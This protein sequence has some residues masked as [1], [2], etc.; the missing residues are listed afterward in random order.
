MSVHIITANS[1]E[2]QARC[3]VGRQGSPLSVSAI[4]SDRR[5]RY[6]QVRISG[7]KLLVFWVIHVTIFTIV[8]KNVFF[9]YIM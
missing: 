3:N 5:K 6:S 2:M 4:R 8:D 7:H 1:L 9:L